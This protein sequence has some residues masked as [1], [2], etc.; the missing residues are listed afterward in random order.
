M[1]ISDAYIMELQIEDL[2]Y[3]QMDAQELE[4]AD[5][6]DW[7]TAD[8]AEDLKSFNLQNGIL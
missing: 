5:L 8:D 4:D 6:P 2:M 7:F 1:P 3:D